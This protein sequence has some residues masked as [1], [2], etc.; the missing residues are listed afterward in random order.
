MTAGAEAG[1]WYGVGVDLPADFEW[2]GKEVEGSWG[3]GGGHACC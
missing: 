1:G 3:C 2:K